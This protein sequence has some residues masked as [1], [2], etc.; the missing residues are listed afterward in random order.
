MTALNNRKNTQCSNLWFFPSV[1]AQTIALVLQVVREVAL[2]GQSI[3][4]LR[5]VPRPNSHRD[6]S[7]V[8]FI[9]HSGV[10]SHNQ[11]E[12]WQQ[13][14]KRGVDV[15]VPRARVC[16]HAIWLHRTQIE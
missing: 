16:M 3:H 15:A 2:A 12:V 6:G 10:K 5:L 4:V 14:W 1:R 7:V 9:R 13:A 8:N 11:R